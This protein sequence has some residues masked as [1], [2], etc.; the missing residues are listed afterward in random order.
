MA[1]LRQTPALRRSA[2]STRFRA[3]D[4]AWSE[5]GTT[6]LLN[7]AWLATLQLRAGDEHIDL[8]R[9]VGGE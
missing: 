6:S 5:Q 9:A 4:I 8:E 7:R 2:R 1:R 3:G